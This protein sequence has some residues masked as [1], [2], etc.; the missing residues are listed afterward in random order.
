MSSEIR[1]QCPKCS[2]NLETPEFLCKH[3]E[4]SHNFSDFQLENRIFEN[5][6]HF[7]IWLAMIED[8]RSDGSGYV[9][10]GEGPATENE[11]YLLC[12]RPKNATS[13]TSKRRRLSEEFQPNFSQLTTVSCT[14]FVHVLEHVDGRVTVVFCLEHSCAENLTENRKRENLKR[15]SPATSQDE[16]MMEEEDEAEAEEVNNNNKICSINSQISQRLDTTADKLKRL[17]KVLAELAV[18]IRTF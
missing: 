18:D 13:S 1:I 16:I 7:Q 17:T 14:A 6:T 5:F 2:E 15:G 10:S 12:R 3:L 8:S 9:G 11:Y 4:K